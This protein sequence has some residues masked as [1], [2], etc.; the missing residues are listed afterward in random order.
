M[1]VRSGQR[2]V[3]WRLEW[4]TASEVAGWAVGTPGQAGLKRNA[5]RRS[6]VAVVPQQDGAGRDASVAGRTNVVAP[7]LGK[8]RVIAVALARAREAGH[9][10]AFARLV[11][12]GDAS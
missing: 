5:V 2:I 1:K 7:D 9:A 10:V 8:G 3:R 11:E 4:A 6:A 12:D